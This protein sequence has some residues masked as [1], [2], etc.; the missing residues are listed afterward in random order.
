MAAVAGCDSVKFQKRNPDVCVPEHQKK[1]L[2]DTPW[3]TQSYLAYKKRIEFGKQEYDEIDVYIRIIPM[4]WMS[5]SK[6][7]LDDEDDF[8]VT[9]PMRD[10]RELTNNP[11]VVT[12]D[13]NACWMAMIAPADA[14]NAITRALE[15]SRDFW[16]S[17]ICPLILPSG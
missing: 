9:H 16:N 11:G 7:T 1:V 17:P 14:P 15:A 8:W 10:I 13:L 4:P 2:R 6:T 3:G 12:S 5:D